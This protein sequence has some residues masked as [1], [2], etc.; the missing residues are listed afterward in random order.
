MEHSGITNGGQP[1]PAKPDNCKVTGPP[2]HEVPNAVAPPFPRSVREGEPSRMS[3]ACRPV[4]DSGLSIVIQSRLRHPLLL[5]NAQSCS[6]SNP[7][8]A[9]PVR[10]SPDCDGC[11]A[12]S[13]FVSPHSKQ[14]NRNSEP[15]RIAADLA[16]SASAK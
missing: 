3:G 16:A 10:A 2:P 5:R 13:R 7:Q 9:E 8:G 6:T 15:A 11:N 14:E 4:P 1:P 12:V